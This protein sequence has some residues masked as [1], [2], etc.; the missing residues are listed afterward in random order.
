MYN[1]YLLICKDNFLQLIFGNWNTCLCGDNDSSLK[2]KISG[3]QEINCE[4]KFEISKFQIVRIIKN[5]SI[6]LFE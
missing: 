5:Y 1:H 6:V 3:G 2:S 4:L